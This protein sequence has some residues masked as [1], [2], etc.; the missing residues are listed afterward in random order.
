MASVKSLSFSREVLFE[1]S[2][3][4]GSHESNDDP[5]NATVVDFKSSFRTP[6]S[7]PYGSKEV[8]I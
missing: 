5:K 1:E 7:M 2:E 8:I 4:Y 3:D 6:P